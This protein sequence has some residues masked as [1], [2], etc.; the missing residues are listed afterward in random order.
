LSSKNDFERSKSPKG[1]PRGSSD[2]NSKA[3][4]V[5]D[6]IAFSDVEFTCVSFISTVR[7]NTHL[8][9]SENKIR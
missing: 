4:A 6:S 7:F 1:S 3:N 5:L 9:E 8:S 2:A